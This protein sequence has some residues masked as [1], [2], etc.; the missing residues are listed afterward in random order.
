M[1]VLALVPVAAAALAG[2]Y[3]PSI[4]DGSLTC[5]PDDSCPSGYVCRVVGGERRCFLL[6]PDDPAIDAS[7]P[8]PPPVDGAEIPPDAKQDRPDA[9]Q[10]P[11]DCWNGA[12]D[13]G[14]GRVDCLDTECGNASCDDGRPCTREFCASDGSC[15][16][17]ANVGVSCGDGCVCGPDGEAHETRCHDDR[18]NDSDGELD[19]FDLEDCGCSMFNGRCCPDGECR[20]VCG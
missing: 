18:D 5:A 7:K 10:P 13:D 14:D 19:C 12:D 17:E 2:C 20:I 4:E 1:R 11:E 16:Y 9:Y 8:P 6:P 15:R 3:S